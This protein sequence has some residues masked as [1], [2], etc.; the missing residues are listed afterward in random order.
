MK[1]LLLLVSVLFCSFFSIA[2]YNAS[3]DQ[4]A[5]MT[6]Y[7]ETDGDNW[8]IPWDLADDMGN[9]YGVTLNGDGRVVE[10]NLEGQNLNGT[11]SS[12]IGNLSELKHLYLG[13]NQLF[14][15][16]PQEIG[17]LSKLEVLSLWNNQLSGTISTEL[18][19]LLSL[20]SLE[21]QSNSLSGTL[22]VEIGNLQKLV[23][24]SLAQNSFSGALP[25]TIGNLSDLKFLD[26]QHNNITA[27][28]EE[29]GN[30]VNLE[31]FYAFNNQISGTIPLSIGNMVSL[32]R[33]NV[34]QNNISGEIPP[35]IG[36]LT[37][38]FLLDLSY[39]NL[40]GQ[41][42]D[43]IGQLG[44]LIFLYL[45]FNSLSGTIPVELENLDN[46]SRFYAFNNHLSGQLIF[47]PNIGT[48][49]A[50]ARNSFVFEDLESFITENPNANLS[51]SL[52]SN[53]GSVSDVMIN[54]GDT[55]EISVTVTSSLNNTYKWRKNGASIPGANMRSLTIENVSSSD[56]GRYDCVINNSVV[57]DLTL[58]KNPVTLVIT[59]DTDNDGVPSNIDLC[60]NTPVGEEVNADGCASSQLDDDNDGVNNTIDNCPNTLEGD[61]VDAQGCSST[62]TNVNNDRATLIALYNATN[63]PNWDVNWNLSET[64]LNKWYGVRLNAQG[65]VEKLLLGNNNLHGTLP[66]ELGQLIHLNNLDLHFN[67]LTGTLPSEVGDLSNLWELNLQVNSLEGEIPIELG[68]LKNL[69]E[70]RLS[71]NKFTGQIPKEFGAL[72]N[73]ERIY[74]DDNEL[75]GSIPNELGEMSNTI[76]IDFSM[77]NLSGIIPAELSSMNNLQTLNLNSNQF[78]G[79]IPISI[80]LFKNLE[81]LSLSGNQ[82]SGS[83]PPELAGLSTL[84]SL[85][86]SSNNLS[87]SIP[88]QLGQLENLSTLDFTYNQISGSIPSELGQ[89]EQLKY[90]YLYKNNLSGSIPAELAQ[91]TNLNDLFLYENNL[92]G[93]I[94][95]ELSQLISLQRIDLSDNGLTGNIPKE[96]GQMLGL[97]YMILDNNFLSGAIPLELEQLHA[98]T[99]LNLANNQLSGTIPKELGQ[100]TFLELLYLNGNE[101]TDVIPTELSQ[102]RALKWLNLSQNQLFGEIPQMLVL[103]DLKEL[104]LHGNQ[105]NSQIPGFVDNLEVFTIYDNH[106]VFN[107]LK[108]TLEN[109]S[110]AVYAPQANIDEPATV[111][112]EET[113]SHT[114]S[115]TGTTSSHNLYQWR[116]DGVDIEGAN[117][118]YYTILNSKPSDSAIYDCV[119]NNTELLGL[120]LKKNP[121][122]FIV[123]A[124]DGDNDKDGI[125]N[126]NDNCPNTPNP[127]QEDFNENG[128]GDVCESNLESLQSTAYITQNITCVG[129][130]D[131][132]ISVNAIEGAEPYRYQLLDVNFMILV[133]TQESNVFANLTPGDYI[134]RVIDA[135]NH[136]SDSSIAIV[137]P[138]ELSAEVTIIEVS[139]L[140]LDDGSLT[141]LASGGLSPYEYSLNG[142]IFASNNSITNLASGSYD[143]IVK[144]TNGCSVLIQAVIIESNDPD[145]DNDGL[146]DACDDDIDGDGIA[147]SE[148]EC[149]KTPMGSQVGFTGCDIFSLPYNNFS[150]Q[151]TGASCN[152]SDNGSIL[153]TAVENL[154]YTVVVSSEESVTESKTFRTFTSFANLS[155]GSYDICLTVEGEA[156]FERCYSV[157]I[158]E[159]ETLVVDANVDV[160]GKS[161]TLK[162]KGGTSYNINL[163]GKVITTYQ[164]EII[165]PLSTTKNLLSVK[166]D[167]DC[168]GTFKKEFLVDYTNISIY[169]NPVDNGEL[170]VLFS[171]LFHDSIHVSIFNNSGKLVRTTSFEN[172]KDFITLDVTGLTPGIYNLKID[173]ESNTEFGRIII[174]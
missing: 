4:D 14:G 129:S 9:W 58:I 21:L 164:N 2:Q 10:L 60:P 47:L 7:F 162:M 127:N 28:P 88:F 83:I 169:P 6:L 86:L 20:T 97:T 116:K 154:N 57:T 85:R 79:T 56:I 74:I 117:Q 73:L 76:S 40:T 146:G 147:N 80:S 27:I 37:N 172:T 59:E 13:F 78:S 93:T 106:L 32:K 108:F 19:N 137:N 101:L 165:L 119:I 160:S 45:Q 54:E 132:E 158:T 33:F 140:G 98:L 64:D 151:T 133:S 153:I 141:V 168:Q 8:V 102:L 124:I 95:I 55:F 166:T 155:A 71:G 18:S 113:F 105:F 156:G 68:D 41:I 39:N 35:S 135:D 43:S 115:V 148:D 138:E 70:L 112:V 128:I 44:Q 87:G 92:S 24:I 67:Q 42:P 90:M 104:Y 3:T 120:T 11:I 142:A 150:I 134:T 23:N 121:V 145:F 72:K 17:N 163:N 81:Y 123:N 167:K 157:Q 34:A 122:T 53:I 174:K 50:I 75:S 46:L 110:D 107:D 94:P 65:R 25:S 62:Q 31:T 144:D 161:I 173:A 152:S 139:C 91:L 30:L 159:P 136:I 26:I 15:T 130:G 38:L 96:L 66:T 118:N 16:I 22:P 111:E 171:Q 51:Y 82:F 77:N 84:K 143:I 52:Q 99:R 126:E 131:A 114:F 5:L 63:G 149:S 61:T 109:Q 49:Y 36:S 29:L 48:D 89:L 12:V 69:K 125:L 100:L 170:T 1:R 103:Q